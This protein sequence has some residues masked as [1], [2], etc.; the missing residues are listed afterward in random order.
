M[1]LAVAREVLE[2]V[3]PPARTDDARACGRCG[4]R[5]AGPRRDRAL[6]A[7]LPELAAEVQVRP[8][9]MGLMVSR[10][11]LLIGEGLSLLPGRVEALIQH[12]VGTHVLTYYNGIAQPIL[13]LSTGLAG[14]D[15]LQEGLAV[16][17][18]YLVGG[19]DAFRMRVLAAR[20]LAAH[21]V[22]HGAEFLET[23]RLL[24]DYG[25]SNHGAFDI[26][27]RVHASGGFTRDMIYLRGLLRLVEYL[28]AGGDIE[29]LYV[30]KIAAKHVDVINELRERGFLR[31][32]PLLP[33]LYQNPDVPARLEAVRN[34]LGLTEMISEVS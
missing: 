32:M 27:E 22:E 21:S 19:L 33:T 4:F 7:G 9:L 30:G 11:N 3:K 26:A 28:R 8:D 18:E 2:R 13:Q 1:L 5:G 10:G 23:F 20:V 29:P 24:R 16:F 25:M 17:S 31:P 12:E 14:Y 15:E 6:P 34:G